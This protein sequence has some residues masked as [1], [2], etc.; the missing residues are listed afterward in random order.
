MLGSWDDGTRVQNTIGQK[1]RS[2]KEHVQTKTNLLGEDS[3]Q[4][5]LV[6]CKCARGVCVWR[7]GDM[8][9]EA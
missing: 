7:G 6:I 2:W 5:L 1:D 8:E 9:S 4:F 3:S